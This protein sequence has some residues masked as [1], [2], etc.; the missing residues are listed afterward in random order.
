[1]QVCGKTFWDNWNLLC[2]Q[3]T[4]M[5]N[6]STCPTCGK[7]FS[8]VSDLSRH[9]RIHTGDKPYSCSDCRKSF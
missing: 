1:C 3:R 6:R 7:Q 4:H 9:Q 8:S 2:H 5:Y